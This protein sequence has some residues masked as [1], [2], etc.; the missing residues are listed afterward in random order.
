MNFVQQN[1]LAQQG[2]EEWAQTNVKL[3][4]LFLIYAAIDFAMLCKTDLLK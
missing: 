1:Q 3:V 2:V 4:Q